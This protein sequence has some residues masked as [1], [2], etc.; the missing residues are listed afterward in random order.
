[1]ATGR[2]AAG[3]RAFDARTDRLGGAVGAL[4]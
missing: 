3:P 2:A 4:T 1:V